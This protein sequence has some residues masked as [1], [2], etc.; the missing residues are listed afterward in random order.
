MIY[1]SDQRQ[2]TTYGQYL[3]HQTSTDGLTWGP[4]VPDV[5]Y[6]VYTD[7]PG[8]PTIAQLPTG[9][10]LMTYEHGTTT[11]PATGAYGFPVT[12]R[13]A[14]DPLAFN[15]SAAIP[16]VAAN[17]GA[18]PN[19]SPYVVWSA[20][21]GENGTLVVSCG[22]SSPV[23]TNTALGGAG[24]WYERATPAP[25][26]YTR[27]LRVFAEDADKLLIIGGGLLPPSTTNTVSYSIVSIEGLLAE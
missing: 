20:V 16:I 18:V 3:V 11:N 13:I 7:R 24:E 17:T 1:Y 27:A 25:T 23:F 21:G 22:G 4:V 9:D 26:S 12:Y 5:E 10:Y 8:M 6:P 14:S 15:A 2:N 19:G